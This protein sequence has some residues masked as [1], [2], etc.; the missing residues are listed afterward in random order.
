MKKSDESS[1]GARFVRLVMGLVFFFGIYGSTLFPLLSETNTTFGTDLLKN[2]LF[3]KMNTYVQP[4][5]IVTTHQKIK[6]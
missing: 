3:E 1:T 4:F 5:R 6:M 2:D